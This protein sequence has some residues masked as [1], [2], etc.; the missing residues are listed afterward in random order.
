MQSNTSVIWL[1]LN[2]FVGSSE[3][4]VRMNACQRD[5]GMYGLAP[6]APSHHMLLLGCMLLPACC[7]A[8]DMAEQCVPYTSCVLPIPALLLVVFMLVRLCAACML[9][10]LFSPPDPTPGSRYGHYYESR[11]SMACC[12]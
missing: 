10:G 8:M 7:T 12:C 1:R 6:A 3:C 5:A 2:G 9:Q 11:K 4:I